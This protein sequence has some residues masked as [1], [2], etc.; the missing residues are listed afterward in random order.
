MTL[1]LLDYGG[2][3]RG[4]IIFFK[5]NK[6]KT[7]LFEIKK[8]YARGGHYHD[9]DIVHTLIIG[10]IEHRMKSLNSEKEKIEVISAPAIIKIP[11]K[12]AN[13]II[14]LTDSL[15]SETFN[16]EYKSTT[17]TEYREIV[18]QKMND[19]TLSKPNTLKI[20]D[21]IK[22]PRGKIFF[23]KLGNKNV[24]LIEIKKGYARGGHYHKFNSEHIVLSGKI[25]YL[26]KNLKTKIE[27]EKIIDSP[28][29][30]LT[31]SQIAHMFIGIEN[32]LFIESFQDDYEA[33]YYPEYRKIIDDRM[34]S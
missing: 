14:A 4:K 17:F 18:F 22:D 19:K 15:F 30:V 23:C 5:F 9:Y 1:E 34:E 33:T 20:E 25:K 26:E 24:N 6:T 28:E 29:I 3:C 11:A 12:T 8:G 27:F 31:Q 13:L 2:D 7:N 10:K 16:R 32:S 21:N